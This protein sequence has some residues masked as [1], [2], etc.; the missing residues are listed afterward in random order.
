MPS[1]LALARCA[2]RSISGVGQSNLENSSAGPDF[3]FAARFSILASSGWHWRLLNTYNPRVPWGF[4]HTKVMPLQ[5][6]LVQQSANAAGC[7]LLPCAD[8]FSRAFNSRAI[9]LSEAKPLP[10]VHELSKP[11]PW[12]A[13]SAALLLHQLT[14]DSA[15]GDQ[16]QV[17]QQLPTV[18]Q[19]RRCRRSRLFP[20]RHFLPNLREFSSAP[21]SNNSGHRLHTDCTCSLRYRP[22]H[23]R[24]AYARACRNGGEHGTP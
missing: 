5:L 24:A 6:A 21:G 3:C 8:G 9:A 7:H 1:A 14:V 10:P 4:P 12:L 22:V 18:P 23:H 13:H 19:Y 16:A 20:N 11:V 17:Y 15:L 2:A